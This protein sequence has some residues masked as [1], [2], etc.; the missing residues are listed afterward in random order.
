MKLSEDNPTQNSILTPKYNFPKPDSK[1]PYTFLMPSIFEWGKTF[2]WSTGGRRKKLP[3]LNILA[4]QGILEAQNPLDCAIAEASNLTHLLGPITTRDGGG[5]SMFRNRQNQMIDY[6]ERR[7]LSCSNCTILDDMSSFCKKIPRLH[8]GSVLGVGG[9]DKVQLHAISF[10]AAANKQISK[11]LSFSSISCKTLSVKCKVRQ[12]CASP[13]F[14]VRISPVQDSEYSSG[15]KLRLQFYF[16]PKLFLF[17]SA[18]LRM[19]KEKREMDESH[20]RIA[21]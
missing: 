20:N 5:R 8:L 21:Q 1:L 16:G 17:F 9:Q 7:L 2:R 6:V 3:S 10:Q 11:S 13:S 15:Y 4:R 18:T 14:S 19:Q 12:L